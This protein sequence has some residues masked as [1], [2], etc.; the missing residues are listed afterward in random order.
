MML[1]ILVTDGRY[2]HT[3]GI[4]RSLK[5]LGHKVD[6]IGHPLCLSSFSNSTNECSYRQSLFNEQNIPRFLEFLEKSKYDFLIPIGAKSVDLVNK[7][8][9]EIEKKTCINLAPKESIDICLN[10]LVNIFSCRQ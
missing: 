9:K 4:I 7:F 8:R 3:L 6:C 2:S 5:K 10:F 1:K